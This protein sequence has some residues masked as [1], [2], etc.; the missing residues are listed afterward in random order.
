MKKQIV[1]IMTDTTRK[2]ML[3]CYGNKKMITPNLD[4]LAENG[5]KYENAYTCQPVCG[6]ARSSIFTG[7]F[8]HTN[9]MVTNCVSLR[10][11]V[12][13]IGQILTSNDIHCGYIGKWHLDGGDYFGY[14][15]CP[16]GW[17]KNYWYDMKNY[18]DELS[19]EDRVKSR[20]S[21]TSYNDDMKEDFTYAHRCSNRALKFLD[22]YKDEDFLLVVSYDEPHG[23]CLCPAPYNTMYE[24]FKFDDD[25]VFNDNLENK[26]LMQR[27]WAG[28]ALHQ[29]ANEINKP[30][31]QLALF[32]G[33]NSFVDYEIGRVIDKVNE[34]ASDAMII[35]TSDHGD[36]LGA[37]KLQMKNACAY[38]EIANIPLII[39][40]KE[41]EK[42]VSYPAS[43]IDLAPTILDYMNVKIPK[44][45]EGKSML[46]QIEDP[47]VRIN[48]E[49]FLEF[50]R[51]E[52]DHDGFGGL[53]M[54]RAVVD[55]RY[56]LVIN[57]LDS[58]E[59]YDLEKDPYEVNNLINDENYK[60]IRNKLH[61][62]LLDNMNR[63]R[64][65]Y[66]GYQWAA[67]YW[68]KDKVPNWN[69]DGY[70]RQRENEENEPRQLDY[71]TGLPMINA[72]RKKIL[73]DEKK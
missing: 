4:K 57:L 60:E 51:Y 63:T 3:G 35:F 47:N 2:D 53:Q 21:E 29:K 12:K 71:D 46:K 30:S 45:F 34:I 66:R 15:V 26:P 17:D 31:K 16:D 24:G 25:T 19:E 28:E 8:P 58:D 41:K 59:F 13:S 42:T 64:D 7:T 39:K 36:M 73:N 56:K 32:L 68:R 69:N 72:V 65:L 27:L 62:K 38:K 22:E 54:M 40:Y 6:P 18:L 23:P 48:D 11:G 33:C 9:G 61:D 37:H 43:H 52:V 55:D 44:V 1:F 50:T 14:G 20:K 49:V 10:E 67:R 5:I 70:T